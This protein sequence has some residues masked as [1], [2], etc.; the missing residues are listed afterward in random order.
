M[1]QQIVLFCAQHSVQLVVEELM[2]ECAQLISDDGSSLDGGAT[3]RAS[4]RPLEDVPVFQLDVRHLC[5]FPQT[6]NRIVCPFHV[7]VNH[8]TRQSATLVLRVHVRVME[9][10][11]INMYVK[12]GCVLQ[13]VPADALPDPDAA[14]AVAAANSGTLG[15]THARTVSASAQTALN[16]LWHAG[17]TSQSHSGDIT[18]VNGSSVKAHT[19][20][21]SPQPS[22]N[23]VLANFSGNSRDRPQ[24]VGSASVASASRVSSVQCAPHGICALC[25]TCATLSHSLLT[26]LVERFNAWQLNL[27]SATIAFMLKTVNLRG[28]WCEAQCHRVTLQEARCKPST[29]RRLSAAALFHGKQR[30]KHAITARWRCAASQPCRGCIVPAG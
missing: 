11:I 1:A 5:Q 28:S 25:C 29:A 2:A 14:K 22:R 27:Q 12:L 19:P 9:L 20:R 10:S 23:A 30:W 6:C 18:S 16:S 21:H 24:S 3:R 7:L 15:A 13:S 4:E 17:T 8:A 26:V